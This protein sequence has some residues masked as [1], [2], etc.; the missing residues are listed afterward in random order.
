MITVVALP[1]ANWNYPAMDLQWNINYPA[2]SEQNPEMVQFSMNDD[3][4]EGYATVTIPANT[5]YYFQAHGIGGMELYVNEEFYMV[6]PSVMGRQPVAFELTNE[7][8]EAVSYDL[9]IAYPAGH[10][11]NP[12]ELMVYTEGESWDISEG[13]NVAQLSE[14]NWNGYLFRWFAPKTGELTIDVSNGRAGWSYQPEHLRTD[15]PAQ[16]L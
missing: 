3:Y 6:L 16:Q 4:T 14:G 11:M 5:T 2:G 12:A 8:E 10:Q 15:R 7:T 1:D 9:R 13:K